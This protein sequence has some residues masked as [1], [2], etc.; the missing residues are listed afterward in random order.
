MRGIG[1]DGQAKL[2]ILLRE[3]RCG[4]TAYLPMR[5]NTANHAAVRSKKP[6]LTTRTTL[7]SEATFVY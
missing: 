6:Q 2:P 7:H 1:I 4:A 5:H 3:Q